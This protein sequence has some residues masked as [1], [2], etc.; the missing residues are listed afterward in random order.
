MNFKNLSI[1]KF[2]SSD[3]DDVLNDFYIPA[4][5]EAHSYTR[6]TGFFSSSSLALAAR[7]I[8]GLIENEGNMKI[9]T[10]PKLEKE[11]VRII[12]DS[13]ENPE[14][15]IENKLLSVLD[16]LEFKNEQ[17]ILDHLYILG[18][19]IANKRLQIKIAIIFKE[20]LKKDLLDYTEVLQMGIFHQKIGILEDLEGNI[21]TFSGSINETAYGW[22]SNIEE[23]KVFR[24]WQISEI[25]YIQADINKF[26]KFWNN[27]SSYIRVIDIPEAVKNKLIEWAPKDI[28][29]V[30]LNRWYAMGK[31]KKIY[32]FE[33]QKQAVQ[34]WISNNMMGIFEMA[35][36][37]G[38]TFTALGCLEK[39][40]KKFSKLI[41]VITC[42]YQHLI[43]Q[44]K[45][46]IDKFGVEYDEIII[47]D[48]T[49]FSW[50][51]NL[52]NSLIDTSLGNKHKI[53]ILTTHRTFSMNNFKKIIQ[54]NKKNL[55]IFLIA[56]EVHGLG[57]K[58]S[59]TGLLK[60]YNLRLGLSATPKRWF[61]TVGTNIIYDY[62]DKVVY[63]FTLKN[64]INTINPLTS[65]TYLTP[66]R[67]IPK[68]INLNKEELGKY[69]EKTRIIQMKIN[70][71]KSNE[72]K[73]IYLEN[74]LF[75]RANIIKNAQQKYRILEEI[76][77]E[78][79][80][81]I[82]LTIIYCSPQQIDAVMKIIN[83]RGII[84]HRFTMEEGVNV[85]KKYGNISER[86][87][88]LQKFGEN[89]YKVLVAMKC[90]DEGVDI[91]P[92]RRAILM[93]SSGNPREYIQRIGRIIRR[94]IGKEEA[95]IHDII[96][97]PSFNKLFPELRA[98]EWKIFEKEIERYE[99]IAINAINNAEA[100][101]II[102]NI[103]DIV[104][105]EVMI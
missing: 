57:A 28:S 105:G 8:K 45:K 82:R 53:I 51:D 38:K 84:A 97:V 52:T 35:T 96:V 92:A 22:Q 13:K 91:P 46:E 37:T 2:Y 11:D 48:S 94:Y 7:G 67:Y 81:T 68:F 23:F 86:E 20:G 70:K 55:D 104:M 80:S 50:K 39:I 60:E 87:F 99:E 101:E 31:M 63:E 64:A 73:D 62:F 102:Y 90:L 66:Y 77:N 34:S 36:G 25:E 12:L 24:S 27:L 76:L 49:K 58:K 5:K 56:D 30:N 41:V 89:K 21:I 17:F 15:Y 26:N 19:M 47:A 14:K 79:N 61:D 16:S 9:I 100:L 33:N 103:K 78:I 71:I 10:S 1:K 85:D 95:I 54:N 29:F 42:P 44:W 98:I 88:L 69:I 93:A 72:D 74:L 6:L 3:E 4:L 43:Q 40:L 75:Q 83:K 18:W 59:S 65:E 32:L